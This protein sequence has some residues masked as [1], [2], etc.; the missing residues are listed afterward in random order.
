MSVSVSSVPVLV[1]N[2]VSGKFNI[3]KFGDSL[4]NFCVTF[5]LLT[6]LFPNTILTLGGVPSSS[7]TPSI[8]IVGILVKPEPLLVITIF[9]TL[10]LPIS[11]RAVAPVPPPPVIVTCGILVKP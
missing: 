10:P 7:C 2:S 5:K 6:F 1:N 3:S 8:V 4:S 9:L 11:E